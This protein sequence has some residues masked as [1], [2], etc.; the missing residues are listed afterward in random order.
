MSVCF[1]R[2]INENI[3]Q[4]LKKGFERFDYISQILFLIVIRYSKKELKKY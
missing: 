3:G 1:W 4:Q 2:R